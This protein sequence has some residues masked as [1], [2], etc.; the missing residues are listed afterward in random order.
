MGPLNTWVWAESGLTKT[1]VRI[2]KYRDTANFSYTVKIHVTEKDYEKAKRRSFWPE[3][4]LVR[5][6]YDCKERRETDRQ[7]YVKTRLKSNENYDGVVVIGTV[8]DTKGNL[9]TI[10]MHAGTTM[11][12]IESNMFRLPFLFFS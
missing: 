10:K 12:T 7:D 9:K 1:F 6:W 11:A 3:C 5:D 4:V 2:L 8:T